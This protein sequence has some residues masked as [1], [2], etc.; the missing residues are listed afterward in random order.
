M[1]LKILGLGKFQFIWGFSTSL[2][3]MNFYRNLSLTKVIF[4]PCNFHSLRNLASYYMSW[5]SKEI[6]S[7]Q[8]LYCCFEVFL[9]LEILLKTLDMVV[10][11]ESSLGLSFSKK[12]LADLKMSLGFLEWFAFVWF[13]TFYLLNILQKVLEH[14]SPSSNT[15]TN[16][17]TFWL[18]MLPWCN[19]SGKFLIIGLNS[20]FWNFPVKSIDFNILM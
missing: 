6:I 12:F 15:G 19:S 7:L 20:G 3:A 14:F 17:C 18:F 13:S 16:F 2:H 4:L 11:E 1:G 8:K 10:L 5:T 9:L